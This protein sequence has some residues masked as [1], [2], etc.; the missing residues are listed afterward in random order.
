MRLLVIV[1]VIII[2]AA[3]FFNLRHTWARQNEQD[4]FISIIKN[5]FSEID[6]SFKDLKKELKGLEQSDSLNLPTQI[7]LETLKQKI[8]QENAKKQTTK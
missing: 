5:V 2:V 6:E 3:W 1:V 8:L 4:T 7:E